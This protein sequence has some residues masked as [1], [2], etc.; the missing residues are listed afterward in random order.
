MNA[1]GRRRPQSQSYFE[2]CGRHSPQQMRLRRWRRF[3]RRYDGAA[4]YGQRQPQTVFL[5]CGGRRVVFG[6]GAA[7]P[8][9]SLLK[10]T[11]RYAFV[12]EGPYAY[13]KFNHCVATR[14]KNIDRDH[15][16]FIILQSQPYTAARIY[17]TCRF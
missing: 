9:T 13:L 16:V 3:D 14:S 10:I 4:A 7:G 8:L 6:C 12:T 1:C 2:V 11:V 17:L 5:V 15:R